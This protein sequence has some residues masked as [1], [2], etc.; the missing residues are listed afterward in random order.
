MIKIG[1]FDV[2]LVIVQLEQRI[3]TLEKITM[4]L[5]NKNKNLPGFQGVTNDELKQFVQEAKTELIVKYPSL[6]LK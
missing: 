2:V 6:G 4:A 1:D 3:A 5:N